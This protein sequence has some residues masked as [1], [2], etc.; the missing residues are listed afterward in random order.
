MDMLLGSN[1]DLP[2]YNQKAVACLI[3]SGILEMQLEKCISLTDKKVSIC[4]E[5]PEHIAYLKPLYDV[6]N[7]GKPVKAEKIVETYTITFTNKKLYELTDTLMDSLKQADVVE[8]VKAGLLGNK[9]SYVP[10]KEVITRIIEK[11]RSELLEDG[12]IS[13]EVI[14][15]TALMEKSGSLK[16]YFSNYEQKELKKKIETIQKSEAG[17][18]AK[19][20]AQHI[21]T[22]HMAA[23]M[24]VIFSNI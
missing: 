4:A 5:L 24:P 13:G 21:E 16:D 23:L 20:M 14:A 22:L 2:G 10:K 15:L 1:G 9:D 17:T 18:L 11:I 7:Q 19:E 12:E 8:P 6:I 3:V